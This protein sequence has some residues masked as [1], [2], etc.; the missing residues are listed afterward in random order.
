MTRQEYINSCVNSISKFHERDVNEDNDIEEMRYMI[1]SLQDVLGYDNKQIK[2]NLRRH[3]HDHIKEDIA[4]IIN[5]QDTYIEYIRRMLPVLDRYSQVLKD[6][7]SKFWNF[8]IDVWCPI[9]SHNVI[10][11]VLAIIEEPLNDVL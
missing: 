10:D 9:L 7:Q 2:D 4:Q 3:S 8:A 5:P 6:I 1:H 11:S